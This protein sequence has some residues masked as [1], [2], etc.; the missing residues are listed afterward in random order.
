MKT[1]KDFIV[2]KKVNE[3]KVGDPVTLTGTSKLKIP[4][5]QAEWLINYLENPQ[6]TKHW[7]TAAKTIA[8]QFKK[9]L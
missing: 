9:L 7:S 8:D 1:Y 5:D 6:K 3:A 4:Y 2:R